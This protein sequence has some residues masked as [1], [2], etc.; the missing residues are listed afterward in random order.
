MHR[1]TEAFARHGLTRRPGAAHRRRR[2]AARRTTATPSAPWTG[3]SSSACCRSSTR[4]TRSPPTR[5]GSATT[6]GWPPWSRT[7][8][9]P[10]LLVLLS[11]VDG[12]YD[13]DPPASALTQDH[14]G[15]RR[16]RPGRRPARPGRRQSA[17]GTG[18][19]ATKVEAARIAAAAG[20]RAVVASADAG[21][22]VLAGADVGTVFT[23]AAVRLPDPAAV[24]RPRDDPRGR[25]R[26]DAGAVRAVVERRHL[27]ARGGRH[28]GRGRLRG[29]RPGGPP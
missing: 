7:W 13:G 26:L 5:S 22:R 21:R 29:R 27:A 8:C 3:C 11:D 10:S 17:S 14:R 16:R 12:L 6:T 4:T 19:M 18:G 24:A 20:V 15:A 28:V 23:P 25:L 9:T 2:G 1:Y